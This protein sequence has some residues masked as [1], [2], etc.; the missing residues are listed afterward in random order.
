MKILLIMLISIIST[1]VIY[2][3][4]K[5]VYAR[6]YT[7]FMVPIVTGTTL[8]VCLLLLFNI[9]YNT[10]MIG[11]KWIVDLLGPAVVALAHPLYKQWPTI[12]KYAMPIMTGVLAGTVIGIIS[13]IELSL[14]FGIE[15]MTLYSMVP[16]SVTSPVAMDIANVI[17]GSPTLAAVFVMVAGISGAV[18]GPFLLKWSGI[19]H[20]LGRGI[21][22]GSASHGIGTAKALELGEEEGAISSIAMTLSAIFASILSPLFV[23]LLL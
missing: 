17:G 22:F 20:Y 12:R 10:Y 1:I 3:A 4:M 7:P 11:G 9:S 5:K 14:L 13:G 18:I 19:H 15:T 6:V 16:K 23:Q 21:G 8:I 2:Q